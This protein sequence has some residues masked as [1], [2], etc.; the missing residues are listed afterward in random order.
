MNEELKEKV[1]TIAASDKMKGLKATLI[2]FLPWVALCIAIII[3]M[4][5]LIIGSYITSGSME[6]TLMTGDR[7]VFFRLA[8]VSSEPKRGDIVEFHFGDDVY[9]KRIIG[10]PGEYVQFDSGYVYINGKKIDEPYLDDDVETDCL[11]SFA[12]PED[13]Y[14]VMG[15]NRENSYDSRY[16]EKPYVEKGDVMGKLLINIPMHLI[17]AAVADDE[18]KGE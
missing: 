1:K 14:F 5:V 4:K 3:A 12:V 17:R 2:E 9:S 15:D 7:A 6:P 18:M 13:S 11:K 8:Y 10:L 16:W